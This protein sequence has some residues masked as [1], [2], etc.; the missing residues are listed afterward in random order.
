MEGFGGPPPHPG[1]GPQAPRTAPARLW[2]RMGLSQASARPSVSQGAKGPRGAVQAGVMPR[3]CGPHPPS[4][5]TLDA[6]GFLNTAFFPSFLRMTMCD[7][8]PRDLGVEGAVTHGQG[9]SLPTRS[10]Q[11][12]PGVSRLPR[13]PV[14]SPKRALCLAGA[15]GGDVAAGQSW[16]GPQD[17]AP[18]PS[19]F[20]PRGSHLDWSGPGSGR[21][22]G[23][24]HRGKA[25]TTRSW[26][27]LCTRTTAAPSFCVSLPGERPRA[28]EAMARMYQNPENCREGAGASGCCPHSPGPLRTHRISDPGLRPSPRARL[29][30]RG[31]D[32]TGLST[33]DRAPPCVGLPGAPSSQLTCTPSCRLPA[34]NPCAQA[35]PRAVGLCPRHPHRNLPR[36][37]R[38][39]PAHSTP[40]CPPSVSG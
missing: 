19:S 23:R 27:T 18:P 17:P 9:A 8:H 20:L 31:G 28:S 36:Y 12:P 30:G 16:W 2:G 6:R 29:W 38:T 39:C 32:G 5:P 11:A 10:H 1:P 21:E 34:A 22:W 26:P 3:A 4:S 40:L 15:G 35:R 24:P 13:A 7:R 37:S 33:E 25:R 14:A